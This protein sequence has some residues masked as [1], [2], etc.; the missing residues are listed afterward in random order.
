M[1]VKT[2]PDMQISLQR[3]YRCSFLDVD[4]IAR[5]AGRLRAVLVFVISWLVHTTS[6][7]NYHKKHDQHDRTKTPHWFG[8]YAFGKC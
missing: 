4:T 5:T 8:N 2:K 7:H 1:C 6:E 3:L